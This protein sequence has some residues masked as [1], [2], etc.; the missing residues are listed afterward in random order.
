M[1]IDRISDASGAAVAASSDATGASGDWDLEYSSGIITA[2]T[3][4]I[5]GY[6][7]DLATVSNF[8]DLTTQLERGFSTL[9]FYKSLLI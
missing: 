7:W 8:T 4:E 5:K 6:D 9:D 2:Q 1:L 3:L